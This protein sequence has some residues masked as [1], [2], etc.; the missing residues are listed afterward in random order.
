MNQIYISYK[1]PTVETQ[2]DPLRRIL[3]LPKLERNRHTGS[4][5][6]DATAEARRGNYF[7]GPRLQ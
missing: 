7:Y 6:V 3:S 1:Q 2:H 5:A 4:G